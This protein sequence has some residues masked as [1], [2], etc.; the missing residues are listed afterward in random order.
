MLWAKRD[1]SAWFCVSVAQSFAPFA[2]FCDLVPLVWLDLGSRRIKRRR[3]V[4]CGIENSCCRKTR[5]HHPARRQPRANRQ[6][7]RPERRCQSIIRR[8]LRIASHCARSRALRRVFAHVHLHCGR[9]PPAAARHRAFCRRARVRPRHQR[10]RHRQQR[11]NQRRSLYPPHRH[12]SYHAP[13]CFLYALSASTGL[14]RIGVRQT[15]S[16]LGATLLFAFALVVQS[17]AC[18]RATCFSAAIATNCR[19][20]QNPK[21]AVSK[22]EC[23]RPFGD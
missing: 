21:G 19:E 18:A 22:S 16:R 17:L 1:E 2:K 7:K 6:L 20:A 23:F 9:M 10:K 12:Q 14:P 15:L 8:G 5:S 4:P 11:H 13:L 3:E